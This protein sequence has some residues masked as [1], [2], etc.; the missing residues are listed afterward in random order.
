[1]QTGQAG[2]TSISTKYALICTGSRPATANVPGLAEI[3]YITNEDL[4]DLQN[5]PRRRG[6]RGRV[7][8]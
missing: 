1:V 3:G 8:Q 5:L 2:N 4:F 7:D 6:Q